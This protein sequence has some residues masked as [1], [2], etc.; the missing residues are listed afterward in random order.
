MIKSA[1][2]DNTFCKF[3]INNE[4]KSE[5][6]AWI[7]IMIGMCHLRKNDGFINRK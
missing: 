6:S 1:G 7:W 4:A 5:D 2:S 3:K